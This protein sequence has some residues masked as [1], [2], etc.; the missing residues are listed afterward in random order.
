MSKKE[1]LGKAEE[2]VAIEGSSAEETVTVD[3]SKFESFLEAIVNIIVVIPVKDFT[4]HLHLEAV[5]NLI[6]LLSVHLYSSQSTEKSTIY[7]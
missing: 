5:N 3:G 4:Y 2:A 7:R 6:T 1:S